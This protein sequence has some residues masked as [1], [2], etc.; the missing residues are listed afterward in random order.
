MSNQSLVDIQM[1]LIYLTESESRKRHI[2]TSP[3]ELNILKR[4]FK[5]QTNKLCDSIL[6]YKTK[7]EDSQTKQKRN[8]NQP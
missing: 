4:D 6:V 1:G 3:Y 7:I 2:V 8:D 5:Q